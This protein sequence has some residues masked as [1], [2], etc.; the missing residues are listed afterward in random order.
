MKTT[1]CRRIETYAWLHLEMASR[2]FHAQ[3]IVTR[4]ENVLKLARSMEE[5]GSHMGFAKECRKQNW[6]SENS[7]KLFEITEKALQQKGA[8]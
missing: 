8:N 2:Y 1:R 6:D 4:M 5:R 7:A 3:S